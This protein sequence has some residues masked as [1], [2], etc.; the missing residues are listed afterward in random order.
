MN[1][2]DEKKAVKAENSEDAA[3]SADA[4]AEYA[5]R[6]AAHYAAEA[7]DEETAADETGSRDTPP[8]PEDIIIALEAE[9]A[10]LT[11][12]Y[13]RLAAEMENLAQA[14]RAGTGG[15]PQIRR[16][17]VLPPTC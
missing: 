10:E 5:A 14:D 13:V 2:Q 12:R 17:A 9:K 4:A 15:R 7:R 3:A 6:N 8:T 16:D 11:D 1:D